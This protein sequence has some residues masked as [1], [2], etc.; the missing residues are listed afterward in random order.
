VATVLLVRHGR[1]SANA[2]GVLAGRTPG[3]RLDDVGQRQA[4]DLGTRMAQLP[5]AAIVSSPLERCRQTAAALSKAMAAPV[6]VTTDKRLTECG[7]GDWTG[8][9]LKDLAKEALWKVVQSQ[10]SAVEFPN[11]ESMRAMQARALDAIR[12]YDA[13]V[14]ETHGPGA[15]WV[16]VSHGDVIKAILADALGIHLDAFQRIVIDPASLSVVRYTPTRPFVVT[17]N[18]S[19]GDMS[20]LKPPAARGRRRKVSSDAAVG[21]GGG[22]GTTP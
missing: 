18:T 7:Y 21:G 10:P 6:T 22:S 1:T 13:A 2:T 3:V 9:P 5:V 12:H 4:S 16:A 15:L 8:R 17:M 20:H 14:S 19:A 11:G